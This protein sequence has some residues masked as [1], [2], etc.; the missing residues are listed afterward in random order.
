M[1]IGKCRNPEYEKE[2]INKLKEKGISVIKIHKERG[3]TPQDYLK[4][5]KGNN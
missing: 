3:R 2:F 1:G 4:D 5:E